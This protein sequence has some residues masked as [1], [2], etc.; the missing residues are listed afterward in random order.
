MALPPLRL[1]SFL[2]I[3]KKMEHE[4]RAVEFSI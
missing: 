4:R 2:A 3:K 1:E